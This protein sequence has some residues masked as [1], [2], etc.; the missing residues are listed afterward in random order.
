LPMRIVRMKIN[1]KVLPEIRLD[2]T[3]NDIA[4]SYRSLLKW[5]KTIVSPR[6]P[7]SPSTTEFLHHIASEVIPLAL[8]LIIKILES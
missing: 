3:F 7:M 6:A 2:M 1:N 4:T 8:F 5:Q